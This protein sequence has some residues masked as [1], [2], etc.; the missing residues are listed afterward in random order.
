[1]RLREFGGDMATGMAPV[2][3]APQPEEVS[4]DQSGID[5]RLVTALSVIKQRIETHDLDPKVRTDFVIRLLQNIPGLETFSKDD[6]I[7]AN[8]RDSAIKEILQNIT[9]ESVQFT[10]DAAD[11]TS[12]E[13]DQTDSLPAPGQNPQATVSSMAK[14]ALKRRS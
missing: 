5:D 8:E 14:S 2:S 1:M 7:A 11:D 10:T 12:A 6:L 4:F 9:P 3:A 13:N